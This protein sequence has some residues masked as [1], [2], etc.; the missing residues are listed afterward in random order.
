MFFG[1]Q[2]GVG[3]LTETHLRKSELGQVWFEHYAVLADSC[4]M[5]QKKIGGGVL[6][7]AHHR[8]SAA[9]RTLT[10]PAEHHIERCPVKL[11]LAS[12]QRAIMILTGSYVPPKITPN[13]KLGRLAVSAHRYL[14]MQ[15]M[16]I[17]HIS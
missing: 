13:L 3:V 16:L 11:Y 15:Q 2:I 10:N 8:L 5:G 7:L 4:R 6:F 9:K 12:A 17:S 14:E 1:H